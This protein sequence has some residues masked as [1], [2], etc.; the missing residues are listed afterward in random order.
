M[1]GAFPYSKPRRFLRATL[2]GISAPNREGGFVGAFKAGVGGALDFGQQEQA[3]AAEAEKERLRQDL[4]ERLFGL[5]ERR[6]AADEARAAADTAR[7]ARQALSPES[8]NDFL[9]VIPPGTM[10]PLAPGS[11]YAPEG[12]PVGGYKAFAEAKGRDLGSPADTTG[13]IDPDTLDDATLNMLARTYMSSGVVPYFRGKNASEA[14]MR[15][16]HRAAQLDPNVNIAGNT[17]D[18]KANQ[19]AYSAAKRNYHNLSAFKKTAVANIDVLLKRLDRI[20]DTGNQLTNQL[21]R[22]VRG[23]FGDKNIPAYEAARR[24]VLTEFT[25]LIQSFTGAGVITDTAQ[26]ELERSLGSN[27]TKDQM[28][29]ALQ[30]LKEESNNRLIGA[31]DELEQLRSLIGFNPTQGDSGNPNADVLRSDQ[32]RRR[33]G[34]VEWNFDANGNLTPS[35][36]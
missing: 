29:A 26:K 35:G 25:R 19:A 6:T 7:E 2:A 5:N 4:E 3:A 17:A 24:S 9:G 10:G 8:H 15:V 31:S 23:T 12:L 20:P 18:F 34:D 16:F 11:I 32:A 33:G 14:Q 1:P 30:T 21:Y 22:S 27:F 13:G 36:Q 28:K